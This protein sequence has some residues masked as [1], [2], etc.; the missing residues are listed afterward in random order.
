MGKHGPIFRGA[1]SLEEVESP[2]ESSTSV[3][4]HATFN[5]AALPEE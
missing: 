2:V 3:S 4:C 1:M 5:G